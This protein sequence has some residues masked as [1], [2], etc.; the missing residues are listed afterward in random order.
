MS[1]PVGELDK[2]LAQWHAQ[3]YQEQQV[4]ESQSQSQ[5]HS[6]SIVAKKKTK[7]GDQKVLAFGPKNVSLS[8][9]ETSFLWLAR[10][11]TT[12]RMSDAMC[13]MLYGVVCV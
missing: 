3:D 13:Y 1:S 7:N 6:Q 12:R 5:L 8:M 11:C 4:R 9:A 10:R 2:V